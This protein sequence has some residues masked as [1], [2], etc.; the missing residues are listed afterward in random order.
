MPRMNDEITTKEDRKRI[1]RNCLMKVVDT[2]REFRS[3]PKNNPRK[4]ENTN[5]DP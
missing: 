4:L 2:E 3:T 1:F 5:E